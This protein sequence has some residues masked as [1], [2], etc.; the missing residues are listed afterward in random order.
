[1]SIP[2]GHLLEIG[3][4]PRGGLFGNDFNRLFLAA[5]R[6]KWPGHYGELINLPA[7]K[8]SVIL[9]IWPPGLGTWLSVRKLKMC[10][11]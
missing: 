4:I 1:M 9:L 11:K 2:M 5:E 3:E 10:K 8:I 6:C 7:T